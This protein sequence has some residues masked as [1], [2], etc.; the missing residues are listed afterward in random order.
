MALAEARA[1][2]QRT[3]NRCLV[4]EDAKRAPKLAYCSSIKHPDY[5]EIAT[6]SSSADTQHIPNTPFNLNSPYPNLSPNSKWWLQQQQS[7]CSTS[8]QKGSMNRNEHFESMESNTEDKFEVELLDVGDF[9]VSKNG[10]EVYFNAE[11]SWIGSERNR[12]WWRTADTDE[13]ASFVAQ[14]SIGCIENCDLPRPQN[15]RIKKN[16]G[17]S[18]QK[19]MSAEGQLVSDTDKRLRDMKTDERMH[20]SENDM[21]MA[22]LMEALRHSQTRAREAE[23]AAKQ[24]C[25]LK[26]DVIKLIFRQASQL[27]AY[28]QWLRLLQLENMY[29]QL[30]NDKRKTQTVSVVFPIMLPSK[31]RST[32]KRAKRRSCPP[33]G[34]GR[35]AILFALGLGLVGAGFL[36][37]CTIGWML[38]TYW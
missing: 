19:L 26:D 23:T 28:K 30:V 31:P 6:A 36:L 2:W 7:N 4:Q 38:P 33:C 11:S 35:N 9:G 8:Y 3:A 1:A 13:L 25:A 16:D 20:T 14:R 12:P 15:T 34:V 32:R 17:I 10:N 18:C 29:Q 22:Q 24:A 5:I 27:F 21:S 37:G